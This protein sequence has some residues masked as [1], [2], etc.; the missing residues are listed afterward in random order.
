MS[1]CS[2]RYLAK[3]RCIFVHSCS[4]FRFLSKNEINERL[5]FISQ[6]TPQTEIHKLYDHQAGP[7]GGATGGEGGGGGVTGG[8]GGTIVTGYK[9]GT[10]T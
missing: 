9:P 8:G 2:S 7:T 5:F 3:V 4:V 6:H 1:S 10:A